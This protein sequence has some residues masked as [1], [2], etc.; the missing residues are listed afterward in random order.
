MDS[1]ISSFLQQLEDFGTNLFRYTQKME[2]LAGR[3]GNNQSEI[4]SRVIQ[5]QQILMSLAEG[6]ETLVK[7]KNAPE[8]ADKYFLNMR[9]LELNPL[10]KKM[11]KL[12]EDFQEIM[13]AVNNPNSIISNKGNNSDEANA[14]QCSNDLGSS[15]DENDEASEEYGQLLL[16]FIRMHLTF[17]C[18][19]CSKPILYGEPLCENCDRYV[20]WEYDQQEIFDK[21]SQIPKQKKLRC[22]T[23]GC[24]ARIELDWENCAVCDLDIQKMLMAHPRF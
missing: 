13:F 11:K 22:P 19:H 17:Q 2:R 15:D 9:Q 5:L 3:L 21:F 8:M 7:I 20:H 18:P 24:G 10:L 6:Y 16:Q 4:K 23:E 14:E 1:K 12:E